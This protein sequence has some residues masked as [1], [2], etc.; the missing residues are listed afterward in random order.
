[1]GQEV[2]F[3][4]GA[5]SRDT[6]ASLR[7]PLTLQLGTLFASC[8][9]RLVTDAVISSCIDGY[10]ARVTESPL[11][12]IERESCIDFFKSSLKSGVVITVWQF[13][14][15]V[16]FLIANKGM[17]ALT[18]DQI[19]QQA[20]FNSILSGVLAVKAVMITHRLLIQVAR[21]KGYKHVVSMCS[22][23][24]KEFVFNRILQKDGWMSQGHTSVYHIKD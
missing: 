2:S 11:L 8:N 19:L 15:V 6:L 24:D 21:L 12:P 1:M 10:L 16:G 3:L 17:S 5:R 22:S 7:A 14:K 13:E 4:E 20:F 9:K 23:Y 18:K